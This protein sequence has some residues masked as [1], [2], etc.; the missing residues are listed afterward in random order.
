[1]Y[2]YLYDCDYG[3]FIAINM[4]KEQVSLKKKGGQSHKEKKLA[5]DSEK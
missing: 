1:M 3:T 5:A 2:C 4:L